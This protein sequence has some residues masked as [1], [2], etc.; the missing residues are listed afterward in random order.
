M[1]ETPKHLTQYRTVIKDLRDEIA[2]LKLKM[3]DTARYGNLLT[4]YTIV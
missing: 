1:I 3:K 2:R 4:V